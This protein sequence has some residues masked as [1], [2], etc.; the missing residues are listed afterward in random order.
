MAGIGLE[1]HRLV[2]YCK[3]QMAISCTISVVGWLGLLTLNI[4]NDIPMEYSDMR[5]STSRWTVTINCTTRYRNRRTRDRLKPNWRYLNEVSHPH[6]YQDYEIYP[7]K[8][9]GKSG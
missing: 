2:L 8:I 5:C 9:Y 3:A 6:V 1:A 7:S 4:R